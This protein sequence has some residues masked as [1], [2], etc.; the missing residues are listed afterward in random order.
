PPP[1][2]S[3]AM[4]ERLADLE[5]EYDDVLA[6]LADPE[7]IGDQRAL[8]DE[9]RR[10]KQLQPIVTRYREY[11]GALDDLADAKEMLGQSSGDDREIWRAM[12]DEIEARVAALE[13]EL[14]LLLLPR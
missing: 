11:R 13:D 14:K 10:H 2:P 6:R 8:R 12:V 4:L 9:S 5:R 7:V 1:V 3:M